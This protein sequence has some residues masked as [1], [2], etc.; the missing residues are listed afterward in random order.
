MPTASQAD[1]TSAWRTL[2]KEN[3][4]DKVKDTSKKRAAQERFME[5]QQAYEILSK[6]KSRRRKQN[7][8]YKEE[9]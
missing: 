8:K 6:I 2:S 7:K 3:H 1:I 5:I 9:L 4:P